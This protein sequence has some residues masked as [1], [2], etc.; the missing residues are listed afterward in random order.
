MRNVL[1]FG[2]SRYYLSGVKAMAT[3][4]NYR[5]TVNTNQ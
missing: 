1:Q 5:F 4:A 3:P 2:A